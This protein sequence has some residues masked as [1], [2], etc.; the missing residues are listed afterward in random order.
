MT[1]VVSCLLCRN[2]KP[3][4]CMQEGEHDLGSSIGHSVLEDC[5]WREGAQGQKE[6]W[7]Q[8]HEVLG[9]EPRLLYHPLSFLNYFSPHTKYLKYRIAIQCKKKSDSSLSM[10]TGS[11]FYGSLVD[12]RRFFEPSLAV[13]AMGNFVAG[14]PQGQQ[15]KEGCSFWDLART[16]SALTAKELSK[17]KH[18]SEIPVLNML[19]SQVLRDFQRHQAS[20]RCFLC[21]FVS[22]IE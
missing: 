19:F 10:A 21:S 6:G 2:R 15:A 11:L 5:G 16:V 22:Q 1:T 9:S 13:D 12:C 20:Q 8:L 4:R 17:S 14:V 18:L 3:S 7:V